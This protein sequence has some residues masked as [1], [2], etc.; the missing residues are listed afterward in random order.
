MGAVEQTK[1]RMAAAAAA[2]ASH[3]ELQRANEVANAA[4]DTLME[5]QA[6]HKKVSA[7][8]ANRIRELDARLADKELAMIKAQSEMDAAKT[9]YQHMQAQFQVA[10]TKENEE[11]AAVKQAMVDYE[12]ASAYA[13]KCLNQVKKAR[14]DYDEA[15]D[16]LKHAQDEFGKKT[17]ECLVSTG[18]GGGGPALRDL[19]NG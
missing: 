8:V 3:G 11:V 17:Y 5:K 18:P 14:R 12:D 4:Q 9:K 16:Q 10:Q 2:L 7:D 6:S 19:F 13:E 15:S 1:A